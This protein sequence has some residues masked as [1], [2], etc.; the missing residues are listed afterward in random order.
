MSEER[1]HRPQRS[2]YCIQQSCV[3]MPQGVPADLR[4]LQLLAYWIELTIP[5]FRRQSGVP[6]FEQKTRASGFGAAGLT[7]A[8][9]STPFALKGT[10]RTLER[11]LGSSKRPS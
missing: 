3:R 11:V 6:F 7:L 1:L 4:N 5:R 8:R 9:I 10:V 2:S